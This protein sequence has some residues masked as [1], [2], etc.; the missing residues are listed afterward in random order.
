M[1]AINYEFAYRKF[2]RILKRFEKIYEKNFNKSFDDDDVLKFMFML[3]GNINNR[4]NTIFMIV[5]SSYMDGIESLIRTSFEMNIALLV[6]MKSNE[7]EKFIKAYNN[8]SGFE[9][10]FKLKKAFENNSD[11]P[12]SDSE[13]NK[14]EKYYEKYSNE[15]DNISSQRNYLTWYE[16]ASNK[17]LKDLCIINDKQKEY[18]FCYDLMSNWVHPQ[19]LEKNIDRDYKDYLSSFDLNNLYL[20]LYLLINMFSENIIY[21]SDYLKYETG[22]SSKL[23]MEFISFLKKLQIDL[24]ENIYFY[25][26]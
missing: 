26:N 13:K 16:K 10:S 7:K 22:N 17:S 24:K 14:L 19:S 9:F 21:L 8:K 2:I 20:N 23:I 15:L 18:F 12:I 1:E 11:I 3:F 25:D 6:F 5:D 4:F